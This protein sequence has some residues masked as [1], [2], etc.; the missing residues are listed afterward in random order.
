MQLDAYI[1]VS[2]VGG[3]AG[4]SFISPDVQRDQI[5][6]WADANGHG[7]T[8]HE[9]ELDVSG[10]T[11]DRPIL[12]RVME[13]I[14]AGQT[15]GLVVAKL[16][17]FS[18]TLVGALDTLKKL[19]EHGAVFVSVADNIDLS[20]PTGRA[21]MRILLV[22]AEL[23]RERIA[24]GLDVAVRNAVRNGVHIAK[25]V[26]RGFDKVDRRLVPNGMAPAIRE[27]FLMRAAGHTRTQIAR[28]LN[29]LAPLPNDGRWT[30]PMIDRMISMRVYMGEAYRGDESNPNAH[31]AIVTPAEW[32]TAQLAPV[33][34]EARGKN[35]NLLGG[36]ARCAGCRYVLAPM[37]S[38]SSTGGRWPS[39]RCRKVHTAGTCSEPANINQHKLNAYVEAVWRDHMSGEGVVSAADT[40]ALDRASVALAQAEDELREFA[41]DLTA[42]RLLGDTYHDAMAARSSAVQKARVAMEQ[43]MAPTTAA[44]DVHR[45]DEL[46]TEDRKR[47]LAASI[48][49]V[50]VARAHSRVP[51]E[52]RVTILWRGTGPD[53]L[54]RRGRDNG[55]VRAYLAA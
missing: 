1:R 52:D 9:P 16:D 5:A 25:Y 3:R 21:F 43:A 44:P 17:R 51:I 46:P 29:D 12:G 53:D 47:I 49:A 13:R 24:E 36:I 48:D 22:F 37:V 40:D 41:S 34:S 30:P 20:T 23:E 55:T 15:G 8:W 6:R 54:P 32:H 14:E 50:F 7:L 33:R 4:D 28:K 45:Y 35:P 31:E 18:R 27:A 38:G 11:M 10:G 2:K 26:P 42:R 19:D 39:Y